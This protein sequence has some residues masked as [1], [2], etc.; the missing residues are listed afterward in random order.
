MHVEFDLLMPYYGDVEL[1][2]LAVRSVQAQ[3]V[4]TW[5]LTVLDDC[6][7][8]PEPARWFATLEDPRI[9]Y[10]RHPQN[11]GANR[12][13]AEAHA[14]LRGT[15]AVFMGADDVMLPNFLELVEATLQRHP[16]AAIIQV[17][18]RTIGADGAPVSSTNDA[19]KRRLAPRLDPDDEVVLSGDSL[20]A[21]LMHGNWVYFPALTWNVARLRRVGLRA[22]LDIAHDLALLVDVLADG[23][24]LVV[25]P[26][27][28][29]EYRRHEESM[30]LAQ[31]ERRYEEERAV[32]RMVRRELPDLEWRRTRRAA[33]L[34]L[35]SR[36]GAALQAARLVREGRVRQ[37]TRVL[38]D[39]VLETGSRR[40]S[41]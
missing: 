11:L 15:H 13:Y 21:G 40:P 25:S 16:D 26:V 14:R 28:A 17:G 32:Y 18:V 10:V 34:H 39:Y 8:D 12:N 4:R 6:Y 35:T 5:R 29:F 1:L 23:G 3:T 30:S 2:K 36:V 27:T 38:A 24:S 9:T 20:V 41:H 31:W 19:V 22:G 37:A 33:A 7:P